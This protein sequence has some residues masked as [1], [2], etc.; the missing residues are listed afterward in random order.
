MKSR[1]FRN[2]LPTNFLPKREVVSF[3]ALSKR[4]SLLAKTMKQAIFLLAALLLPFAPL[5]AAE[6]AM[7]KPNVLF[8]SDTAA[9]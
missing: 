5:R 7:T 6:N 4:E 9:V 8:P 1:S 2:F 3:Q